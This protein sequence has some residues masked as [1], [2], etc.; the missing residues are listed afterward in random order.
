MGAARKT[1]VATAVETRPAWPEPDSAP[2]L[3]FRFDTTADDEKRG[4]R[5]AGA[6]RSIKEALTRWLDEQL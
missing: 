6:A 2:L 3:R 5:S 1:G 4:P